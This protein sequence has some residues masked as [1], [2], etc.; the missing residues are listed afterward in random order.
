MVETILLIAILVIVLAVLVTVLLV[1]FRRRTNA[2]AL[3]QAMKT[4]SVELQDDMT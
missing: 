3:N 1:G 4:L 2:D